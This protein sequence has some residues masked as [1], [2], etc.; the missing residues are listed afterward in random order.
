MFRKWMILATISLCTIGFVGCEDEEMDK[1]ALGQEC[2]EDV[3]DSNYSTKAPECASLVNGVNNELAQLIRCSAALFE[4]GLTTTRVINAAVAL[5]KSSSD[6]EAVYIGALSMDSTALATSAYNACAATTS[7]GLIYIASLSRVGTSIINGALGDLTGLL[8]DGEISAADEAA[9]VSRIN[10]CQTTPSS[11]NPE[12]VGESVLALSDVYCTAD[13]KDDEICSDV[14]DA[15][16]NG[17]D[18][19]LVGEA[20]FCLMNDG[21]WN[22]TTCI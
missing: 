2:L 6:S 12:E 18:A 17:A 10:D 9:I 5:N 14:A 3:T 13:K 8:T 22:G 15:V 16:A 20:M 7:Q 11:C 19:A 1:I 21:N 4:G